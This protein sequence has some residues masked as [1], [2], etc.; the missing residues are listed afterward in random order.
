[1]D[2]FHYKRM[3]HAQALN[4]KQ[5]SGRR[6]DRREDNGQR[7]GGVTWCAQAAAAGGTQQ[8][9]R[10]SPLKWRFG[11][12]QKSQLEPMVCARVCV[13]V[14]GRNVRGRLAG[15]AALVHRPKSAALRLR[16]GGAS[17]VTSV[18]GLVG[19]ELRGA[20]LAPRRLLLLLAGV[21]PLLR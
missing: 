16:L 21:A 14:W 12:L 10:G 17:R 7:D 11:A 1:M 15:C 5:G 8:V 3:A 2:F 13:V 4:K 6:R 18:L 9:P 20:R 19:P